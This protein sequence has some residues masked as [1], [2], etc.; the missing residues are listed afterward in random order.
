MY[1]KFAPVHFVWHQS[2]K[3]APVRFVLFLSFFMGFIIHS[4][5]PYTRVVSVMT[6]Q[7]TVASPFYES[8]LNCFG[9]S[10]VTRYHHLF[11]R[12]CILISTA[13]RKESLS[14][15]I[16]PNTVL[17]CWKRYQIVPKSTQFTRISPKLSS[18]STTI[19]FFLSWDILIS[20]LS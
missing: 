6:S 17:F 9:I 18:E 5:L 4:W 2:V 10:F 8:Y 1:V 15:R 13:S 12:P 3:L 11:C 16:W 7:I 19:C 20:I 14:Q